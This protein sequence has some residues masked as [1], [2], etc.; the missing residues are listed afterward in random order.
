MWLLGGMTQ[1]KNFSGAL[2]CTRS[3]P[4]GS[5]S[6]IELLKFNAGRRFRRKLFSNGH[7]VFLP[8]QVQPL[9]SFDR[10]VHG[11][12]SGRPVCLELCI[13]SQFSA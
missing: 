12:L 11:T 7:H 13:A 5:V 6:P 1:L 2:Y 10:S 9:T 8:M 4:R 3:G